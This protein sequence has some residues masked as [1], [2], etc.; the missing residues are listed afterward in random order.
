MGL[1][2]G[3]RR[4]FAHVDDGMRDELSS[5]LPSLCE[6]EFGLEYKVFLVGGFFFGDSEYFPTIR[7]D[8]ALKM[9]RDICDN[10]T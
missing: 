2:Q 9:A 10:R 6:N 3:V 8:F 1:R 5:T 7:P 4:H